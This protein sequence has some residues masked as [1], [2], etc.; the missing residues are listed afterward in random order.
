MGPYTVQFLENIARVRRFSSHTLLAYSNDLRQFEA[1]LAAQY[2]VMHMERA[3]SS[4]IRSWLAGLMEA[5]ASSATVQRKRSTLK[6]FYKYLLTEGLISADPTEV[7]NPIK[8]GSRLPD[9]VEERQLAMLWSDRLYSDNWKGRRDILMMSMFYTT[10][11]RLSELIGLRHMDID[12]ERRLVRV[13]GKGKKVR[14]LPILDETFSLYNKYREAI[15]ASASFSETDRI[16]LTDKSEPCYTAFVYRK[17]NHYLGKVTTKA[18]KSPHVLRHSFATHMLNAGADL[19]A[20]KE[21]LGHASLAATQVYTHNSIEK[22][23]HIYKQAHP[24]A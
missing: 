3:D 22:I 12:P 7:L 15:M 17:V 1:Y 8:S 23:K 6:S 14:L 2:D 21:L 13:F 18:K 16:F 5:D 4:M 9:F 19:N 11:M 24:K 10:G 20:I